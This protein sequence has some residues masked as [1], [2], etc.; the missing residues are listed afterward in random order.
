M[1]TD[2]P[3]PPQQSGRV[4][5][6]AADLWRPIDERAGA[7]RAE[8]RSALFRR[9]WRAWRID[10][11]A[12]LPV[13]TLS[14][15]IGKPAGPL[16]AFAL[17]LSYFFLCESLTGQ[18]IGKRIAGLRVV[19]LDGAPLNLASVAARNLLLLVDGAFVCIIG[20]LAVTLT[21]HRQRVGDLIG[22]TVVTVADDHPHVPSRQRGRAA[23]LAAYPALWI[24][25]ALLA[26]MLAHSAAAGDRYLRVANLTCANA[27]RALPEGS[28]L[29]VA[30]GHA[31]FTG[32]ERSLT[33][34]RPPASRR[35][36]H[37]RLLAAIHA[38]RKLLGRA[39]HAHG[40][41][42]TVLLAEFGAVVRKN[43]P[44]ELAD[45]YPGC[46]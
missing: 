40:A 3:A 21:P 29:T 45:G 5:I 16:L 4:V 32:L 23:V 31:T 36:G 38:E 24:G 2:T 19:R 1:A 10:G 43:A 30:Q 39:E 15:A 35:A 22:G 34:L 8:R 20:V 9:R 46:S 44:Q 13:W 28:P 41:Q 11:I 42:R 14:V 18:T 7:L 25:A 37:E 12:L 6:E 27:Q 33:A 26:G 17:S